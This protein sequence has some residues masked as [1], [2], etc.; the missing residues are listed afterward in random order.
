MKVSMH[1]IIEFCEAYRVIERSGIS[2][3]GLAI[4]DM[5][6]N[7]SVM[8]PHYRK[9]TRISEMPLAISK[10]RQKLNELKLIH[11]IKVKDGVIP[12]NGIVIADGEAYVKDARALEEEYKDCIDAYQEK[13]ILQR[14]MLEDN[15]DNTR[16]LKLTPISKESIIFNEENPHTAKMLGAFAFLFKT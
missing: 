8:E 4:I 5:S 2:F 1:Q 14:D 15:E 11:Q 9:Y 16:D 13:L 3:K 12:P 6:V 10:Y 7:F